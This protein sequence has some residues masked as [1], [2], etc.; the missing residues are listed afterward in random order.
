[1]KQ[2]HFGEDCKL[3][4]AAM[5]YLLLESLTVHSSRS[6]YALY[7]VSNYNRKLFVDPIWK[8]LLL[9]YNISI[10]CIRNTNTLRKIIHFVN[11]QLLQ[12]SK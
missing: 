11:I 3:G 8:I 9:S 7:T 1:M 5:A 10:V 12:Y 4:K 6:L 2:L